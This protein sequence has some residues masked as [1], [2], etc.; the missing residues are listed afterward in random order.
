MK[1]IHINMM[2]EYPDEVTKEMVVEALY[3]NRVSPDRPGGQFNCDIL[4]LNV[5]EVEFE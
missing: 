1:T 5:I 2:V 3:A 4:D